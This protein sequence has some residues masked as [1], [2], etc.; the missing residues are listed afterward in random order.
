VY[1][2]AVGALALMTVL[3]VGMGYALPNLLPRE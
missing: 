1:L 3:S 2:G